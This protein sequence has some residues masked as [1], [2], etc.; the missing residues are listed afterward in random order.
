MSSRLDY[1]RMLSDSGQIDCCTDV[2]RLTCSNS[3]Q[4][5]SREQDEILRPSPGSWFQRS[6]HATR[7]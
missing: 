4:I 6:T 5:S 1:A 7:G 3:L 2:S